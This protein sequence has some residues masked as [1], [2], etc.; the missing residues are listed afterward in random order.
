MRCLTDDFA[1]WFPPRCAW[2]LSGIRLCQDSISGK[3]R[4]YAFTRLPRFQQL[5][6]LWR[7]N[8]T[9]M[10]DRVVSMGLLVSKRSDA[11]SLFSIESPKQ[12]SPGWVVTLV[13]VLGWMS[14]SCVYD[15]GWLDGPA[16]LRKKGDLSS[17]IRLQ[18]VCRYCKHRTNH[19]SR[20]TRRNARTCM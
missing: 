15:H 3:R 13:T 6:L 17:S 2:T 4:G 11:I 10:P 8:P 20:L 14:R 7:K 19:A 9:A 12:A 18:Y 5:C 1:P 16:S